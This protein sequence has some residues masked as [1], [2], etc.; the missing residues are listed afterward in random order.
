MKKNNEKLTKNELVELVI[1]EFKKVFEQDVEE[2]DLK[3]SPTEIYDFEDR[4]MHIDNGQYAV[5]SGREY[6]TWIEV[7]NIDF[8]CKYLI[9]EIKY[10]DENKIKLDISFV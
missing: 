10:K 7:K 4:H 1:K 9:T 8:E 2:K 5:K 3:I 6:K